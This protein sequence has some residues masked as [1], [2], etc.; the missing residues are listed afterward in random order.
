M[1]A[2]MGCRAVLCVVMSLLLGI[3]LRGLLMGGSLQ[4]E[5]QTPPQEDEEA[6]PSEI[7]IPKSM[8]IPARKKKAKIDYDRDFSESE[9]KFD[10]E[11]PEE[12][13][14]DR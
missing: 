9:M 5:E 1:Q 12:E 14:F 6:G 3:T 10:I 7:F 8:E 4:A 11:I 2:D 13:E